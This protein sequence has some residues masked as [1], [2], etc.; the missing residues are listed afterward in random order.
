[1]TFVLSLLR[2]IA[3]CGPMAIIAN[4]GNSETSQAQPL[5]IRLAYSTA[6]DEQLWLL[7][8]R[9]EL[10][11]KN[12]GKAYTFDV[13]RMPSSSARAQAYAAG[14]V[15]LAAGG[16]SGVMLAASEGVTGK[17]IAS[18]SR[19]AAN[20]F[21]VSWYVKAD[22]PIKTVADLKG[23]TIGINGFSTTGH[24]ELLTALEKNGMTDA[25]VNII[26]VTFP[27]MQQTLEAGKIDV[28]YFPQP[29][30][31]LLERQMQV[32]KLFDSRYGMPFDQEL[33]VLIG[34]EDFLTRN[35][36]AIRAMMEDLKAATR[37]YLDHP[38]EARQ[39]LIDARLVRVTPEVYMSMEDYYRDPTLR[40][41]IDA[42]EHTQDAMLKSG[43][44]KKKIDVSSIVDTSYLPR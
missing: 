25:D 34:A 31:A 30:A 40:P 23:K 26:P 32:R 17:I 5:N 11:A 28:G 12:Y 39:A 44:Q 33:I 43:F 41:D 2:V 36:D 14:A 38:K 42:L 24:L 18:I 27:A 29:Y 7:T 4:A 20:G 9:P 10:F 1:M 37:Y 15:D 8:V 35:V 16:G 19:Q 22:S 3:L 6:G 21:R 13:S